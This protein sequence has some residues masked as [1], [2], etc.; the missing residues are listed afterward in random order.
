[1]G[2]YDGT[3]L[4]SEEIAQATCAFHFEKPEGFVFT[5]HKRAIAR[6]AEPEGWSCRAR[7][8]TDPSPEDKRRWHLQQGR[9]QEAKVTRSHGGERDLTLP[10]R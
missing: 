4:S 8:G 10:A 6:S 5:P 9:D 7:A 1:M 3:L 2:K